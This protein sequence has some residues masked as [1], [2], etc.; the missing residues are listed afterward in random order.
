MIEEHDAKV[1]AVR[2][3][4]TYLQRGAKGKV[5][6]SM[7]ARARIE[8]VVMEAARSC[9]A[10]VFIGQLAQISARLESPRAKAYLE[11]GSF[12][13]SAWKENPRTAK[14]QYWLPFQRWESRDARQRR[15]LIYP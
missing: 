11:S 9:N 6:A 13:A 2:F 15:N 14:R 7:F 3:G 12:A 1:A 10:Q 5:L 4:E 8:G